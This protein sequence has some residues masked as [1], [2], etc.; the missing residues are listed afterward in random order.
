MPGQAFGQNRD[1]QILCRDVLVQLNPTLRP[2]SGDGIDVPFD[3]PDTQ[4][5]IDVALR[6][7]ESLVVAECR[8]TASSVK[9][10]DV[11]AFAYKVE[12][13]RR[14]QGTPVAASFFTKTGHQVGAV[15]VGQFTG[16]EIIV[17]DER[18]Q[19]PGFNMT[20][21][22]FDAARERAARDIVMHIPPASIAISVSVVDLTL[23]RRDGTIETR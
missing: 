1:Y 21:L 23:I 13:L 5:T 3:L 7:N 16:I 20:F 9:Q 18:V 4:W 6:R 15:K 8:C 19:L 22:R 10:E 14:T 11:A 17:L 12:L 2:W